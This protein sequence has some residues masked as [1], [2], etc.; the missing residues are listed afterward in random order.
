MEAGLRALF[1]ANHPLSERD[2]PLILMQ[3]QSAG[4]LLRAQ[5]WLW[6]ESSY[7]LPEKPK[8]PNYE[9]VNHPNEWLTINFSESEPKNSA[10]KRANYAF[11]F[12]EHKMEAEKCVLW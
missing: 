9:T 7:L 5:C 11:H 12:A 4:K 6:L 1:L 2:Q 3:S 8:L 10:S